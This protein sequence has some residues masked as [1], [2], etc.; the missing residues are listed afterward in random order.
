MIDIEKVIKFRRTLAIEM[1]NRCS[2]LHG[3]H[4]A[5]TPR[6]LNLIIISE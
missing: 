1:L 5:A 4:N 3:L 6:A 2:F